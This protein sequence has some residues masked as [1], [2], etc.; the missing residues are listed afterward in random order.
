MPAPKMIPKNKS[1]TKRKIAT[2][3]YAKMR[4]NFNLSQKIK[5]SKTAKKIIMRMQI[6]RTRCN[7]R[8]ERT[9]RRTEMPNRLTKMRY[10]N[11]LDGEGSWRGHRRDPQHQEGSSAQEL[12]DRSEPIPGTRTSLADSSLRTRG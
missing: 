12:S 3:N 1:K 4:T 8:L 7:L 2:K 10:L 6:A 11:F 9:M 5:M